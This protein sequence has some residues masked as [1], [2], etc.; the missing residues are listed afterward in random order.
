MYNF[1]V[2]QLDHVSKHDPIESLER[3][4]RMKMTSSCVRVVFEKTRKYVSPPLV[5]LELIPTLLKVHK[6]EIIRFN[7]I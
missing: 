6:K 5:R 7:T 1:P 2:I 4:G 3:L